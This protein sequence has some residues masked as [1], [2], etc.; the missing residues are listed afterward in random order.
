MPPMTDARV[1]EYLRFLSFP[2]V[3]TDPERAG[4]VA[5]CAAWLVEKLGAIGLRAQMHSTA[6]HPIVVARN[7]HRPGRR[8]VLIYGHYD[9]QPEDPVN[10][11]HQPNP[12]E[13]VVRDGVLYAR[14]STDNKGQILAHILG[15]A[16]AIKEK[17]DVPVNLIF[18]IE[19]E[20]EVGSTH[21]TPF[22]EQHREA[23]KCDVIA[24]SDTG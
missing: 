12:F 19:G 21:L 8:T 13:P 7:E 9:V 6:G 24:V 22:L 20:E 2:S 15:V 4:D 18:L 1:T 23:L 3:S 16:E 10:E 14:G 5:G 11:W 17:G